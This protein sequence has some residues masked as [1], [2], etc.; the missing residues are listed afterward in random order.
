MR[1]VSWNAK[2]LAALLGRHGGEGAADTL[3]SYLGAAAS[4]PERRAAALGLRRAGD[5]VALASAHEVL[6]NRVGELGEA[7]VTLLRGLLASAQ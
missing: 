6:E 2:R 7:E 3:L 1:R 4:S 5:E